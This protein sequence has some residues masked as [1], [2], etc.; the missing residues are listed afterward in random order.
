VRLQLEHL[1]NPQKAFAL[2]RMSRSAEGALMVA[3][4]CRRS[5]DHGGAI[6]F[7]LLARRGDEAFALAQE[8]E[9]MPRF[10]EILGDAGTPEEYERLAAYFESKGDFSK[11]GDLHARC[12]QYPAAVRNFLKVGAHCIDKAIEVVGKASSDALTNLVLDYLMGETDGVEKDHN[13]QFRLHIALRNYDQAARTSVI[14]ARQEQEMGNYKIAHTQ[15]FDTFKELMSEGKKPPAELSRQL[16]LLHSYVLVKVLVKL[17]DHPGA[18]RMLTRV[19]KNI[20]KFPAHVVPILTSTVIECQRAGLK[21]TA[22]EYAT[23]LMAPELRPQIAEAYKRKIETIVRKP[24]KTEA[25]EEYCPCPFCNEP[26]PE[27]ELA[28]DSCKRDIPFCVASGKRMRVA[29]WA[30]CPS[31]RFPCNASAFVKTIAQEKTCPMCSQQIVL[32]AIKILDD[33]LASFRG[34]Q[35]AANEE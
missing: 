27:T 23:K 20:S 2:V 22:L 30:Q 15:L 33:P 1:G 34:T 17:G 4:F 28:C 16:M 21:R 5:G 7:L 10:V 29:D 31:C 25:S 32:A 26:G 18:A 8:N 14:I 6:E 24:D 19:A 11:A 13:Y 9:E 3:Q 35:A 12:A